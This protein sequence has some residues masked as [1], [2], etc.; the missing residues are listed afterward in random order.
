MGVTK[1]TTVRWSD[2]DFHVE[3]NDLGRIVCVKG[4]ERGLS[5]S[6]DEARRW[7]AL[8][9]VALGDA[10]SADAVEVPRAPGEIRVGD[11][12]THGV[13]I[14]KPCCGP[15]LVVGPQSEDCVVPLR[16]LPGNNSPG[17][18]PAASP[19]SLHFVR[20]A[21]PDERRAAGLDATVPA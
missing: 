13:L 17:S 8:L 11:V 7:V 9:H 4:S 19:H 1:T 16:A 21:T 10:K 2:G 3:R 14:D 6:E 5:Y 20:R 12:V 18:V 15:W